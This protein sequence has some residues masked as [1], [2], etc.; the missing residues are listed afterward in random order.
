MASQSPTSTIPLTAYPTTPYFADDVEWITAYLDIHV[1]STASMVYAYILWIILAIIVFGCAASH[2]LG[3][4]TSSLGARWYKWAVRRRTW[5]KQHALRIAQQ[6]GDPHRQPLPLPSNAQILTLTVLVIATMALAFVGPD[7]FAPGSRIWNAWWTS[8]NRTGLIAFALFPLCV[9]LALKAPPFAVLALPF[10]AQ[11]HFDKLAWIH[12]WIGRL[13]WLLS[14]LHVALWSVQLLVEKRSSTGQFVYTYAFQYRNFIYGWIAF[15]VMTLL[16]ASSFRPIRQLHY[17]LFYCLHILLVPLTLIFSALHHPPVWYWCWAALA[18]W[19]GERLWRSIW[20]MQANGYFGGMVAPPPSNRLHKVP[21]RNGDARPEA[22]EMSNLRSPT[23]PSK[24][25]HYSSPS[26]P[27]FAIDVHQARTT[28]KVSFGASGR[29]VAPPGF[30]H[31]ELLPGRTVRL[32][33]ITPGYLPWAPGQHFLLRVP[34]VSGLTTHPFT[35]ATVCDQE[36]PT[37]EGRE[38]VFLIRAKNGWTKRLW[39]TVAQMV[40]RGHGHV[41]GESLP[42]SYDVPGRGVLLRTYVDGPFGSAA[43]A[44]WGSYSTVLIVAGGSGVSFGLSILQYMCLCLAGRDGQSLG[45]KKGGWGQPGFRTTRVR[46]VWLVREFSHIQ[47]CATL[48]R[49]C[50]SMIPASELQ[51]DIFVTNVK[52]SLNRLS[53]M[54]YLP[55]SPDG[56]AP[57]VPRFAREE[58]N[59][60]RKKRDRPSSIAS[61]DD[62]DTDSFVDLSYYTGDFNEGGELGHEEHVLDLTNFEGD[63][64]T[65]LPGESQ[66]N[67]TVKREGKLR[68]AASQSALALL[69]KGKRK[70]PVE[71]PPMPTQMP[72]S[73]STVRLVDYSTSLEESSPTYEGSPNDGPF[74]Q[75]I[76][77]L[78]SPHSGSSSTTVLSPDAPFPTSTPTL[79]LHESYP[80]GEA[81]S[82]P[83]SSSG[84]PMLARPRSTASHVSEYSDAGSLAA[85]VA[86]IDTKGGDHLRLELDELEMQDVGIVAEHA[87]PGKP[88][89][90]RIL[91]DEVGRARGPI[92]VGC[93]GPLSLNAM[94]RKTIAAQIDPGR[95]RRGDLSG[96]ITLISEDFEY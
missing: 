64:D 53:D 63:D 79:R 35:N 31:A 58:R 12:K 77:T 42:A 66:F 34:A 71:H 52:P 76:G 13:I 84:I 38:L 51:V 14:A 26:A 25:R 93:C 50:M 44:R 45:G 39:D 90:D 60:L 3:P 59:V 29:Y 62:S 47:W 67:Q 24:L 78:T 5:R 8:G 6:R 74:E 83:S 15:G 33:L 72:P 32:R 16:V 40:A 80:P 96:S 18:V 73:P 55:D 86:E 61:I 85:L 30:A 95:I 92:L 70:R 57:P 69:S 88:K 68:R 41:P 7:Y 49:R 21:T 4:T 43:R 2:L 75:D 89:L 36:A 27:K 54:H 65:A 48:L 17:E 10:V 9:L 56:L 19:A 91:E 37:D 94:M 46:F 1:L 28:T 87:R 82:S 22:L 20:W 11:L 81:L 23:S